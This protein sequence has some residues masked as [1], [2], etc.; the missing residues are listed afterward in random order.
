MKKTA[1]TITI[2]IIAE[3]IYIS[4]LFFIV[5]GYF[6]YFDIN[7]QLDQSDTYVFAL[8]LFGGSITILVLA[9]RLIVRIKTYRASYLKSL[10][11]CFLIFFTPMYLLRLITVLLT[12]SFMPMA[13]ELQ[14][15]F[16][17]SFLSLVISL[18]TA[19]FFTRN[20]YQPKP[21]G[22]LDEHELHKD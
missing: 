3:L 4:M 14:M 8:I 15:L 12:G 7:P 18:I 16:S 11:V 19:V 17:I 5:K 6:N 20:K 9:M 1:L 22:V 10:G 2:S 13:I 21:T